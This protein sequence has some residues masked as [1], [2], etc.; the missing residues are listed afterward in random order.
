M[1]YKTDYKIEGFIEYVVPPLESF[2]WIEG[3]DSL[4]YS[5]KNKYCW[6]SVIR[7]PD[8]VTKKDMDWAIISA[9]EKKKIDCSNAEFLTIDE[10]GY[11][12]K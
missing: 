11:V 4:D 7:L 1:S 12:F 5:D 2:W 3:Q 6:I 8:F 10:G 9:S